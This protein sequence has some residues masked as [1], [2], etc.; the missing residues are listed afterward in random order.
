MLQPMVYCETA[1]NGHLMLSWPEAGRLF[2]AALLWRLRRFHG[3]RHSGRVVVSPGNIILPDLVGPGIRIKSGWDNWS[4][5][6]LL[7]EDEFGDSLLK[8]LAS[9]A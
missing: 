3:L 7:S 9:A 5:Y 6:Y 8:R 1:A 4:G 2:Y